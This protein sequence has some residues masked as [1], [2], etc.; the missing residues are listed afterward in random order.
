MDSWRGDAAPPSTSN[1]ATRSQVLDIDD[2]GRVISV[3]NENDRFRSDDDICVETRFAIPNGQNAPLL[4]APQSRRISECN[5]D[6]ESTRSFAVDYFEYDNLPSGQVSRGHVT[7]QVIERRATDDGSLLDTIRAFEASY[8]AAGNP[9]SIKRQR[10]DYAVRT[11]TMD[12]DHS[13]SRMSV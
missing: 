6:G 11:L 13:A 7:S 4:F 5:S 1:V 8:D 12:Y 3:F 2:Y 10:E 9:W